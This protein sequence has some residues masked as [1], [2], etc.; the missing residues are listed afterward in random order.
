[1]RQRIDAM[2]AGVNNAYSNNE[3]NQ[4]LPNFKPP[5]PISIP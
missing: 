4:K 5:I 3:I 2:K 1:M